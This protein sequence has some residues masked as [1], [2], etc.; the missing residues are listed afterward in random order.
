MAKAKARQRES[1]QK[2]RRQRDVF[3][4]GVGTKRRVLVESFGGWRGVSYYTTGLAAPHLSYYFQRERK[5]GT[6]GERGDLAFL[7]GK[8]AH[9]HTPTAADSRFK[10][11]RDKINVVA[12]AAVVAVVLQNNTKKK[13]KMLEDILGVP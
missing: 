11:D 7:E 1:L 8:R 9:T 12:L 2:H 5:T 10:V 3:H 13:M 6:G 4:F